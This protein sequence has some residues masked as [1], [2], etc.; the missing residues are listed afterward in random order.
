MDTSDM[1]KNH[2]ESG[3]FGMRSDGLY[4]DTNKKFPKLYFT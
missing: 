4:F 2:F 1:D 3:I